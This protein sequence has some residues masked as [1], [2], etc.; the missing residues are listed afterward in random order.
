MSDYIIQ[1]LTSADCG[2]VADFTTRQ[3][4]AEIVVSRGVVY[5]P[6]KLPGFVA[7]RGSEIVGLITFRIDG[8]A[9]EIVTLNSLQ[10]D[11][12]IGTALIDAV[13]TFARQA[14]CQRLFL[15]TTNDNTHALRFYQKR[16]FVLAAL[17][18]NA[19]ES[20]RTLKP[21]IPLIGNDGIPLR[22]EIELEML[23]D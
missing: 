11:Q 23:L 14:G 15:V 18:R 16:G 20:A 13:R 8:S 10:P 12:G 7:R 3:W 4:G 2:W 5:R 21:E 22:D 19:A 9:C 17:Y 6:H 1:P